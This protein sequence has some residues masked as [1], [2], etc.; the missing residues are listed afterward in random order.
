MNLLEDKEHIV[1]MAALFGAGL[2]VFL[3]LRA[4]LVP[5][6]FGVYGH[7]RA[8]A[9]DDNRVRPLRFAGHAT[10][11]ECHSDQRAAK[12]LGKHAGVSCEA[13]HGALATHAGDNSVKPGKPQGREVCLVCHQANVAKPKDFP[14][15][16]PAEHAGDGLCV[17]CHPAHNPLSAAEAA[18]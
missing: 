16:D 13:C 2:L 15:V 7:F 1:R 5:S 6:G 3:C 12:L 18:K 8:G 14:R 11:E 10:C 4:L 9:I 17:E